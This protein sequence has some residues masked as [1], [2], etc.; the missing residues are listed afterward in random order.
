MTFFPDLSPCTYFGEPPAGGEGRLLTVGWLADRLPSAPELPQRL[1]S[2]LGRLAE[3]WLADVDPW[4]IRMGRHGCGLCGAPANRAPETVVAH[5]ERRLRLGSGFIT[6]PAVDRL[7]VAPSLV[8]H[9]VTAHGYQPPRVF[10][11]ALLNCP[12]PNSRAYLRALARAG[13]SWLATD[14]HGLPMG[15]WRSWLTTVMP[16]QGLATTRVGRR[17]LR[18]LFTVLGGHAE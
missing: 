9:Y 5:G 16:K 3:I 6:V 7:F 12:K 8:I 18:A 1:E 14:A 4:P 11:D 2:V 17:R 10:V 13:G 15:S